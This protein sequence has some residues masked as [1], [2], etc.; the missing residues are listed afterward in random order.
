MAVA[1]SYARAKLG[2]GKVLIVDFDVHHG[3]GTQKIFFQDPSVFYFSVHRWHWGNYYPFL[4]SGGPTAV[5]TGPGTG[6]NV[7]VGWTRKGMG[8]E[9]YFA[10]WER[11]LM[12]MAHEFQPNLILVSS[13]FDG[14]AG[15]MGECDVSPECFGLLTGALMSLGS[16][17]C[18]LEGGYV[19]S[20]LQACVKHVVQSLVDPQSPRKYKE[21]E[22]QASD[23]RQGLDILDTIEPSAA[24]CIQATIQA[25]AP[26]WKCLGTKTE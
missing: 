14:A 12:P 21:C 8:D 2:V 17:V 23:D 6:Y 16:V 13:G 10:V 18:A 3:Q 4:Q 7:N 11:L 25:H 1:A 24:K 5:G 20:V 19:R 26:Y 9:E 15:D 22:Q